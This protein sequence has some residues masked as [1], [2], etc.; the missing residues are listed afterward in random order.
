[1]MIINVT[2]LMSN[3]FDEFISSGLSLVDIYADWCGTCKMISPIIDELSND[4]K[5]KEISFGKLN[6]D[7]NTAG[8]SRLLIK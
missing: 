7:D 1:M 8:V 2:K 4:Y 3:N 5:D 6:A